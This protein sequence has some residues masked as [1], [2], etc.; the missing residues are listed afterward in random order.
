MKM[1]NALLG[2]TIYG[3]KKSGNC[4]KIQLVCALLSIDYDWIDVDILANECQTPAFKKLNPNAKIPLLVLS[5]GKTISE[6]NAIVNFLAA[7]SDLLPKPAFDLAKVQQ[8]QFFEQYS[9][10]PFIAVARFINKYL[11]LPAA[12]EQE[13]LAKQVGGHKALKVMEEQLKKSDYLVGNTMSVADISLF[14]YTHVAPEGG[15]N[16]T[17]YPAIQAWIERIENQAAYVKMG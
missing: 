10:E 15:V 1:D 17:I 16:L 2:I 12:R 5:N 14:A 6:S 3:D 4:Y 7:N 9:H 13:Y 11:G 8:W